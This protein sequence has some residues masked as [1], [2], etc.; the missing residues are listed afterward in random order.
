MIKY[1]RLLHK[2]NDNLKEEN[3]RL[4]H[5]IHLAQQKIKELSGDLQKNQVN[6]MPTITVCNDLVEPTSSKRNERITSC[7]ASAGQVQLS[8]PALSLSDGTFIA[9]GEMNGSISLWSVSQNMPT[10]TSS[11]VLFRFS[12]QD[13]HL[14]TSNNDFKASPPNPLSK[15]T[16]PLI[17]HK[18]PVT[19]VHW[20]SSS[21][22]SSTSLDSTIKIWDIEANSSQTYSTKIPT[23]SHAIIDSSIL[24]ASCTKSV[25]SLD[26]RESTCK[27]I[28]LDGDPIITSIASTN[29]GIIMGTDDGCLLLYDPRINKIYQTLQISPAHLPISKISGDTSITVT[30]FDGIVRLLGNELPLFVEKVLSRAPING[31][32]IG[33]CCV[34]LANRD[35]FIVSGSTI[36]KAIVWT[37][38]DTFQTLP[39]PGDC[40][41]DCVQLNKFVGSFVT[42]DSA[43]SLIMWARSFDQTSV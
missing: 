42:C 31:S 18:N 39:H 30:S 9:A 11:N 43:G 29:L 38:P 14:S 35:D 17:G 7:F 12:N 21:T 41:F 27:E 24:A 5:L 28:V 15:A 19:S 32:I 2:E 13:I 20:N 8:S 37:S 36:G 1:N 16:D 25:F 10:K 22:I 4:S 3:A 34:S 26:T 40:V 23:I 6:V 33:S